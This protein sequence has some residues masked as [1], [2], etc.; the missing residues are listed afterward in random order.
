MNYICVTYRHRVFRPKLVECIRKRKLARHKKVCG[1]AV[2]SL[3]I[4]IHCCVHVVCLREPQPLHAEDSTTHSLG[5]CKRW[6]ILKQIF[7]SKFCY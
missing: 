4:F 6:S 2:T 3:I 7:W 1:L 5:M